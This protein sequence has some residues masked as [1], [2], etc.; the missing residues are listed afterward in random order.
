MRRL[1]AAV[2]LTGALA[3]GAA[4]AETAE[5]LRILPGARPMALGEAYTAVSDDLS[6]LTTNPSGLSRVQ[7]R[8][9]GF[10]H[11]ELYQTAHYDFLGYTQPLGDA[12]VGVGVQRMAQGGLDG[13][14][15]SGQTTGSFGAAD[16]AI[17]VAGSARLPDSRALAGFGVKLVES[18]LADA[19]ARTFAVDAGLMRSLERAPVPVSIGA[20][21]RN[22]GPGL[23]LGSQRED[24]PLTIAVGA[25]AR[26]AGA[27]LVS[28][29][30]S[31]RPHARQ[32]A[33]SVGTEYSVLPT[34]ALRAG[35]APS[36]V[37]PGAPMA[38]LGFGFGLKVSRASIDYGFTPA[39]DLG[40]SQ[41]LSLTFGF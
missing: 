23:R 4:A 8:Q 41:R 9:A 3:A 24:L 26:L 2:A 1:A 30:V 38:G 6:A 34:F 10:M 20:A 12:A 35:Y 21:V 19:S 18:R 25:S 13:R 36:A 14:D 33:F 31:E 29:D 11:A 7:G 16:T 39:G 22:L 5:F 28:A 40:S 17:T 32:A 15:A 27:F 37:T